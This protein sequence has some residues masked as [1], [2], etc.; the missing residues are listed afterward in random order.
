[1]VCECVSIDDQ[2]IFNITEGVIKF[3]KRYNQWIVKEQPQATCVR[4][5]VPSRKTGHQNID[6]TDLS[7][8][9]DDDDDCQQTSKTANAYIEEWNLYLNTHKAMPDDIEIV[10]WWGVCIVSCL[11]IPCKT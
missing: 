4:K 9:D 1:M 11:V 2:L 8:E 10:A 5:T 6:N 7:S 3:V